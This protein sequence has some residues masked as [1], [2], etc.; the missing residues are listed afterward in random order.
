M[1]LQELL[2]RRP[3]KI[4]VEQAS[5][6]MGVTPQFIRMGLRHE[7]LPF[8]VGIKMDKRWS[9]YI[10]TERFLAYVQARDMRANAQRQNDESA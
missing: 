6:I 1:T 2:Q 4:T 9:Y 8:G 3:P 5:E 10:N 7:R